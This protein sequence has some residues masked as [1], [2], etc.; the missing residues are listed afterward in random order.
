M[1]PPHLWLRRGAGPHTGIRLLILGGSTAHGYV[2]RFLTRACDE[3]LCV[4][5][6]GVV[7]Q[8]IFSW[9]RPTQTIDVKPERFLA[10]VRA[11]PSA[12][13]P[14]DPAARL[15]YL[16]QLATTAVALAR[17]RAALRNELEY[18]NLHDDFHAIAK[19]DVERFEHDAASDEVRPR[20]LT[21][22]LID[23]ALHSMEQGLIEGRTMCL[24]EESRQLDVEAYRDEREADDLRNMTPRH[25]RNHFECFGRFGK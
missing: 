17:A 5:N 19:E 25:V 20:G 15:L 3:L 24:S 12:Q 8:E 18:V 14:Q 9:F 7:D 21:D 4:W 22:F 13:V 11:I 16:S 1:S 23:F 6:Y 10:D 2:C